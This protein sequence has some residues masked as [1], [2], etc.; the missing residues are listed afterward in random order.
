MKVN[1][2]KHI[3]LKSYSYWEGGQISNE[4]KEYYC[5]FQNLYCLKQTCLSQKHMVML[6]LSRN[7]EKST[8]LVQIQSQPLLLSVDKPNLDE[9]GVYVYNL[10]IHN[11][12]KISQTMG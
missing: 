6:N 3:C 9:H 7:M 8:G 1:T 5:K 12:I 11:E 4:H 2:A 10:G